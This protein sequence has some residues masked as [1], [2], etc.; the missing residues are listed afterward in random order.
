MMARN[1]FMVF[2]LAAVFFGTSTVFAQKL[3]YKNIFPELEAKNYAQ[4][5]NDLY[6]FLQQE[7]DHPNANLQMAYFQDHKGV[8]YH[9]LE[10]FSKKKSAI[11]SALL[12]FTRA[13]TLIDEKE[14]KRNDEFYQVFN[15]RD[16]RTG[17]FAIKLSDV[18]LEMEEKI[19]L[20]RAEKQHL[21]KYNSLAEKIEKISRLQELSLTSLTQDYQSQMYLIYGFTDALSTRL[22]VL[23]KASEELK[24]HIEEF[25]EA[26]QHIRQNPL[27]GIKLIQMPYSKLHQDFKKTNLTDTD[28]LVFDFQT[29]RD[30]IFEEYHQGFKPLAHTYQAIIQNKDGGDP[31]DVYQKLPSALKNEVPGHLLEV[32]IGTRKLSRDYE[33]WLNDENQVRR[34]LGHSFLMDSLHVMEK[35]LEEHVV[36]GKYIEKHFLSMFSAEEL[37]SKIQAIKTQ[38]S[39]TAIGLEKFSKEISVVLSSN[40]DTVQSYQYRFHFLGQLAANSVFILQDRDTVY[41]IVQ[42]DSLFSCKS[43]KQISK[44]A[45]LIYAKDYLTASI[46]DAW[47]FFLLPITDNNKIRGLRFNIQGEV[48]EINPSKEFSEE[49]LGLSWEIAQEAGNLIF[50][51]NEMQIVMELSSGEWQ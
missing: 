7:K 4:S 50:E 9:P 31:L 23:A 16:L 18:Q 17:K 10:Q 44:T 24:Q 42:F 5:A 48:V 2:F 15:R 8:N 45:D 51:V 27:S 46:S 11:D 29:F 19:K 13:I 3:K 32:I 30:Q 43:E 41:Q 12:Y 25:I 40:C 14:I 35:K 6:A 33:N 20:L 36:Q 22:E 47:Y 38:L 39:E 37:N 21:E 34:Y 26:G 1:L 49:I 28:I